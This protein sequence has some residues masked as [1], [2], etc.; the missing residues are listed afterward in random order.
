V[1]ALDMGGLFGCC[2][3]SALIHQFF[4][5]IEP[6]GALRFSCE[7]VLHYDRLEF[8]KRQAYNLSYTRTG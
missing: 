8:I 6:P 3:V 1:G 2:N 7:G 4:V 5:G